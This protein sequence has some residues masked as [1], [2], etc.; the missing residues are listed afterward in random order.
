MSELITA[1]GIILQELH[2][3]FP[4]GENRSHA[5]CYNEDNGLLL[6]VWY[7]EKQYPMILNNEDEINKGKN[8]VDEIEVLLTE[9]TNEKENNSTNC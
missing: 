8:L 4:P 9:I 6:C 5:L 3:R 7:N 1:I 2:G